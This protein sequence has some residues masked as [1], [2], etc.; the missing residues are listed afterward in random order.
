MLNATTIK[1]ANAVLNMV[2]RIG[3]DVGDMVLRNESDVCGW[4]WSEIEN[5]IGVL[6]DRGLLV[7]TMGYDAVGRIESAVRLA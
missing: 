5:A 3:G 6:L 2:S 4:E 7:A 1:A